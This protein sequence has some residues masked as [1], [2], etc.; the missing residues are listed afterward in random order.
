MFDRY[1]PGD[2]YWLAENGRVWSS[3][4]GST[5]AP[6]DAGFSTWKASGRAPTIWPRD[7]SGAQSDAAMADVLR[8]YD[9][10]LPA[11]VKA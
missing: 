11:S 2:W 1:T 5:V 6:D 10:T 4:R 9:L 8:P 3:R 7:E